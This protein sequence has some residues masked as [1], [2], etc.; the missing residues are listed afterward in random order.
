MSR[1]LLPFVLALLFAG[2]T[3]AAEPDPNCTA[4]SSSFELIQRG[5]F[6]RHD[7][8]MSNCHGSDRQAGVDLREGN[9][10]A[11]LLRSA[12]EADVVPND[13]SE[14]KLVEP[15]QPN[16]SLLWLALAAKTLRTPNPDVSPMPKDGL[17]LSR[18]ELEAVRLWIL[19]GAPET[20]VVDGVADLIVACPP[21]PSADEESIAGLPQCKWGD[22][23][24]LLPN[25]TPDPP[26]DVQVMMRNGHR[27]VEFATRVGNNGDGPL[28]IQAATQPLAAGQ[29][30]DA[31]Q[32]ILRKDGSKCVHRAGIMRYANNRW[33]V[34]NF[35]DF[36]L[37]KDDPVNGRLLASSSKAAVCLLDTDAIRSADKRPMQYTAHCT[38]P[39]G[40][41]G[42]SVGYKDTYSR[43]WPGQWIDL[44]ADPSVPIEPG[45]YYL[46]NIADPDSHLWEKDD[47]RDDNANYATMRL[48]LADPDVGQSPP[49]PAPQLDPTAPPARPRPVLHATARPRPARTVRARP[50]LRPRPT[51]RPRPIARPRPARTPEPDT[52]PTP[53]TQ[54]R[55][56]VHPAHPAA[57]QHP[58]TP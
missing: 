56:P 55:H 54:S 4:P 39:V 1:G 37:R 38:D 5:I 34:G 50:T 48:A 41:M 58:S 25:L 23:L 6:D 31:M 17:P 36:E 40:R 15:G 33:H 32:V 57:P 9:S 49:T 51:A 47:K 30:V 53:D 14:F 24:L 27:H 8:S 22:P 12:D 44:D 10:Y 26:S 7:C 18:D 52:Q 45:T 13:P 16:Q 42:I 20:G 3:D 19:A 46:I 29:N 35:S 21:V 11:N 28:I 43:V 2:A